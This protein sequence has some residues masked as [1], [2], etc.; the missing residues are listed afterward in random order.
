MEKCA[1]DNGAWNVL[2]AIGLALLNCAIHLHRHVGTDQRNRSLGDQQVP[3]RGLETGL[4][5][6]SSKGGLSN[7]ALT[8]LYTAR[9]SRQVNV[10]PWHHLARIL[11]T[12]AQQGPS[13]P[14]PSRHNCPVG[15]ARIHLTQRWDRPTSLGHT[16]N[17]R[18]R[19]PL[20][21]HPCVPPLSVP[22]P[23]CEDSDN[24]TPEA[25]PLVGKAE[26]GAY[27]Q[28]GAQLIL[29]TISLRVTFD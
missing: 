15:S 24:D 10:R 27:R 3:R 26:A 2:F 17:H 19:N 28:G 20:R 23:A 14:G 6:A 22:T 25:A 13:H 9:G 1:I 7:N 11:Q 8:I 5:E 29:D 4:V 16:G 21:C 12:K 18:R